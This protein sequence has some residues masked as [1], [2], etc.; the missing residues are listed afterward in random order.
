MKSGD[1][2][3]LEPSGLLQACNGTALPLLKGRYTDIDKVSNDLRKQNMDI[4]CSGHK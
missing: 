4:V 3:F 1:L 2:N